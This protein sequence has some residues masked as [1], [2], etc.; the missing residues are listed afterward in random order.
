[1]AG[2]FAVPAAIGTLGEY[3]GERPDVGSPYGG[4]LADYGAYYEYIDILVKM[5]AEKL[6]KEEKP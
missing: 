2:R 3:A 1:M 4:S 5:A 6:F